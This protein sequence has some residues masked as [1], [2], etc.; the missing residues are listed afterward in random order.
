MLSGTICFIF[1]DDVS[2]LSTTPTGL[3]NQL[4]NNLVFYAQ[5][6]HYHYIR[7]RQNQIDCLKIY[8]QE[9]KMKINKGKTKIM[10]FRK[11]GFFG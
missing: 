4:V 5:V 6:N 10:V 9:R 8:C 2:L 11:S 7:S 1:A 3:Q